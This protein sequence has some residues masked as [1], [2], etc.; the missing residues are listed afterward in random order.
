MR[1]E[2]ADAGSNLEMA[3]HLYTWGNKV[4]VLASA[5]LADLVNGQRVA[6]GGATP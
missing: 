5:R 2:K 4:E 1:C 6:W 3:W